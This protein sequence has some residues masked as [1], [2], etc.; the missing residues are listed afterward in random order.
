MLRGK[1]NSC[2]SCKKGT[3]SQCHMREIDFPSETTYLDTYISI[4]FLFKALLFYLYYF[5]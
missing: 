2:I 3:D 1:P 4:V 5:F